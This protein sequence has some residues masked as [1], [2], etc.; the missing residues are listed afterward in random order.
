MRTAINP[1][2]AGMEGEVSVNLLTHQQWMK[3]EG[4]PSTSV[5]SVDMP[6]S[7]ANESFGIGLNF[8]NDKYGFVQDF[9]AGLIFSYLKQIGA[10]RLSIGISPMFFNE[11]FNSQWKFPD[12]PENILPANSQASIIDFNAGIIYQVNNLNIGFSATHLLRPLLTFGGVDNYGSIKLVNHFYAD[13]GYTLNIEKYGIE[14]T[15]TIFAKSVGNN[16]QF[17]LNFLAL[18]NKKFWVGVSYR[19]KSAMSL[20]IGTYLKNIKVGASYDLP[21][22]NINRVS[23]GSFELYL[24]YSF[25]FV[26]SVEIQK[27]KNVKT[28]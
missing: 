6:L 25:S 14:L 28:L 19:N 17:E 2:N 5:L 16:F 22:N 20:Q 11:K 13:I 23:W 10:G 24:G 15:P 18:Y 27:Y 4:A 12:Q 3:F 1:A 8:F 26:K 7:L 9:K 21:I